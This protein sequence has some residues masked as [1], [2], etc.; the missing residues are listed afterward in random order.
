MAA[1]N[2]SATAFWNFICR[3]MGKSSF[4]LCIDMHAGLDDGFSAITS[5]LACLLLCLPFALGGR[6]RAQYLPPSCPRLKQGIM[7]PG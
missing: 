5:W 3:V 4:C 1:L 2:K 7:A 6:S